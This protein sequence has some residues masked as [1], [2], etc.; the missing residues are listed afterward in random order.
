[1]TGKNTIIILIAT[2]MVVV[3]LADAGCVGTIRDIVLPST[4]TPM[5]ATPTPLPTVTA[6]PRPT[7]VPATPT[8]HVDLIYTRP[9]EA[10]VNNNTSGIHVLTGTVTYNGDPANAYGILVDTAEGYEY[11]NKT[12]ADGRFQVTFRDDGSPTYFMKITDASNIVIYSDK[13]LHP[14]NQ[15]GPYAVKIEVPASKQISVTITP[16][17]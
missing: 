5:P 2:L 11:G 3:A 1:M 12:N 17:A 10:G 14:V 16:S 7:A 4:P 15:T 9:L 6:T 13:T 8:P